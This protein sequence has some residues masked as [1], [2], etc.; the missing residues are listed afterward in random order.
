[1]FEAFGANRLVIQV[2]ILPSRKRRIN[3]LISP[4]LVKNVETLVPTAFQWGG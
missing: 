3:A 1:M 4:P 2:G